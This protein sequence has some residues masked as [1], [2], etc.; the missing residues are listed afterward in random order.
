MLKCKNMQALLDQIAGLKVEAVLPEID[1]TG[2]PENEQT[3]ARAILSLLRERNDL[4]LSNRQDRIMLMSDSDALGD[5]LA[6]IAIGDFSRP[7]AEVQLDGLQDIRI[8]IE[9]MQRQLGKSQQE[10]QRLIYQIR[11]SEEKF[12][13]LVETTSDWI[14]ELDQENRYS[15]SSPRVESVIGY[16]PEE[17]IGRKP[18]EFML[19]KEAKKFAKAIN[20][21]KKTA[22]PI[23]EFKHIFKHKNGREVVLES[24]GVPY[25]DE[26]GGIAGYRGVDRD[27]TMRSRM[28][29]KL[30]HMATHDALTG[31]HNRQVFNDRVKY[32]IDRA[33]RYHRSLSAF[34]L[35]I[36]F[37]KKV[38]DNYGHSAGDD[39]LKGFAELLLSSLRGS[40]F[41]ARYGGEEFTVLL[42][43][44]DLEMAM[45]RA[46][47]LRK[48]I[49]THQFILGDGRSLKMTS[50]IGVA[51]YPDNA[52][53]ADDLLKAA[54][55][56]M[57]EAKR[58]GRNRAFAAG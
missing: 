20:D 16:K 15:Y 41:I 56:A 39:V 32:E 31:L 6:R 9:D 49:E 35:D 25:F 36:D 13:D 38:N 23:V 34:L 28:E 48:A 29:E 26:D 3:A 30:R 51:A 18:F 33:D 45:S 7:V 40:D 57:Y 47:A 4:Y 46:D 54:D 52:K 10:L 21:I 55:R 12:R 37:F 50:S 5:S 8:G 58:M 53:S 14:W 17:I 44:T 24:N 22:A 27:I 1:L 43:E 2:L 42:P 11:L 19:D